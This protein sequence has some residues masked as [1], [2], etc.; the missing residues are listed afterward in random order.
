MPG[1]GTDSSRPWTEGRGP[2]VIL[3]EP[4]L[5]ENIGAAARAMA[6][7]GL[8]QL[9]LVKPRPSWPSPKATMMAAGA[10]RILDGVVLFDT[11]TAAIADC[12]FVLATTA[13]AH[14]QAKPVVGAAEAAA[15]MAARLDGGETV[16]VLFGRERNGLEN[17][18]VALADR[19]VTLPVNPAFASLNLAQAVVIVA[20]EWFKCRSGGDLPF[21]MPQK[22][23]A[24]PKQQLLAFF[25]ALEGELER[26]EF[27]RPPDKRATMQINLR[28]IFSRMQPTQQDIRTLHGVFTAIAAGRKGPARGGVLD[29]EQAAMLRAL[30]AEQAGAGGG[31]ERSPLR[32]LARLLRR[33][34]TEAERALWQALT[35]DRRFAGRGFKRQTPVGQHVCDF[36]SFPLHVVI[37]LTPADESAAAAKTRADKRAWLAK[38]GYR[39]IEVSAEDIAADVALV[40]DRLAT[41]LDPV[42]AREKQ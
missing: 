17:E 32:G 39:V 29:S 37:D 27:F 35:N 11:L 26:V 40:L 24:A 2:I 41:T 28:N 6:N 34:P 14:D 18:E 1:A 38:R 7:F 9:R 20:Y 19:I 42:G 16:A 33:N 31:V 21:A 23:P 25:A 12:T 3:V 10:D 5:G 36:V 13:R 8:S 4:Q 30:I 15:E 22:S